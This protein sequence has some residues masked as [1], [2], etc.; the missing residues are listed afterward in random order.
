MKEKNC[1]GLW[2]IWKSQNSK[3]WDKKE[4]SPSIAYSMA[5]QTHHQC[6]QFNSRNLPH[7]LNTLESNDRW[8]PLPRQFFKCNLDAVIFNDDNLF[9]ASICL[10]DNNESFYKALMVTV[11]GKPSSKEAEAW[12]LNKQLN[13]HI[14]ST[15]TNIIWDGL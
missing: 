10:R 5:M 6:Q 9:G 3:L 7:H 12:A 1:L 4:M 13:G 8:T 14:T 15:F 2:C 11:N